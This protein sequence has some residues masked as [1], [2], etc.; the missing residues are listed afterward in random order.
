MFRIV[1]RFLNNIT[2]YRL[3]LYYLVALLA[4]AVVFSVAGILPYNPVYLIFLLCASLAALAS[5]YVIAIRGKHIFNPAALGVVVTALFLDQ[6]ATWWVG[7][8]LPMLP[9]VLIGGL[10]VARK[11]R[12]TDL[13]LAFLC[14]AILSTLLPVVIGGGEILP[15]FT[16]T[17]LRGPLFFF[18]F[19]M[20]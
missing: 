20:L 11:L 5:K 14:S 12:H 19:V 10:L 2:M 16:T 3:L 15:A 18:A 9:F 8:N 6:W 17:L 13:V 7:G 1:D 4:V